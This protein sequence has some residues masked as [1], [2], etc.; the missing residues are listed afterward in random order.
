MSTSE[1]D[2]LKKK[3]LDLE[4][5][6]SRLGSAK[7]D[8]EKITVLDETDQV[9]TTLDGTLKAFFSTL[10]PD[11][12]QL[13][14]A[15]I[16]IG[17][18]PVL[19][20]LIHDSKK[21]PEKLI[22]TLKEIDEFYGPPYGVINYQLS[23]LKLIIES[24]EAKDSRKDPFTTYLKPI[25]M[26]LSRDSK[27]VRQLVRHG[28]ENFHQIGA[29]YPVGGAGE[30][31]KLRDPVTHEPLPVATLPLFGRTLL[32]WLIRD[33]ES[34][35]FLYYKL[36]GKQL[37]TPIAMMTSEESA[38]HVWISSLCREKNWFGRSEK[39]FFLFPQPMVPVSTIEGSWLLASGSDLLVKPG[40]HGVIW[41]LA[42]EKGVLEWF[43]RQNR[44]KLLTRQVNNPIAGTDLSLLGFIGVGLYG[45]YLFGFS[46]CNR[47]LKA[48]E[49][50]NILIEKETEKGF[51]YKITNIEYTELVKNGIE[52]E[53]DV[54]GGEF[55]KFPCNT[56]ILFLDIE[57]IENAVRKCP[58]PGRLI[59]MKSKVPYVDPSGHLNKIKAGRLESTMQNAA[60]VIVDLFPKKLDKEHYSELSTYSTYN[61][62]N[63]TISVTKNIFTDI[64]SFKETPESCF[65]DICKNNHELFSNYCRMQL[66]EVTTVEEYLKK[67]PSVL[68]TYHP[69]LGPLYSVISQKIRG[70]KIA[71]NSELKLEI[72]EL[73]IEELELDG[74]L[75]IEADH[76]AGSIESEIIAYGKNLGKCTLKNIKV[77]NRGIDRQAPNHYWKDE[78]KRAEVLRIKIHG[79]GELIAKDVTLTGNL[80]LEVQDGERLTVTSKDDE[81]IMKRDKIKTPD[82]YWKYAFDSDDR[83]VLTKLTS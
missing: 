14:K 75:W 21:A 17:Q 44:F 77:K 26:D 63:K 54:P 66:P 29:I 47:H 33:V 39:N 73:D 19:L 18:A 13:F 9:K 7:T 24:L 51:E 72:A 55:S 27:E 4:A 23:L 57:T 67:G 83:V 28:I 82:A 2:S 41:K 5:I 60:D 36:T 16:V 58:I 49:G 65:Y 42:S 8:Q 45:G 50:L 59:N 32:E 52:D 70:G 62:R 68:I 34:K 31:L 79:N 20:A 40:G 6:L 56:N 30:R 64:H 3:I 69:A 81:L 38:N 12:N 76:V 22:H 48:S 61:E 11:V 1:I 10:S 15:M 71:K 80:E 35:E 53:P 78:I 74:S 37:I 25:G 43:K 46:A